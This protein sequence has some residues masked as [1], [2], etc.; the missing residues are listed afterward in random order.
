MKRI[1]TYHICMLAFAIV[2]NIV[3]GEIALL[4]HLPIYLDSIGTILIAAT[5]GPLYGMLP[6]VLSGLIFGM[7]SDIYSLYYAP[8]GI[9]L[10]LL[11]G[12]VWKRKSDQP[13]WLW[14]SALV[15]TLPT[16]LLSACITAGVFGG[17]TSSGSAIL[18]QLLAK[19]PLGLTLSCFIVQLFSEY[20][21]RLLSM[22][23]VLM[24]IKKLPKS[25]LQKLN[26]DKTGAI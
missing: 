11:T 13:H 14:I 21:D 18:V 8:V 15:I 6:S 22:L 3:G 20:L 9:L 19:T 24:V 12:Y 25:L 10:G 23:L 4:L 7:S 2:I 16:S 17:I 5:C 26:T 1:S